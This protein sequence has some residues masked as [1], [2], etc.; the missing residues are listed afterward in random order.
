MDDVQHE[1]QL[2][3]S[4][5]IQYVYVHFMNTSCI[6]SIAA[7][8]M[9]DW[10]LTFSD[11]VRIMWKRPMNGAKVLFILNRYIYVAYYITAIMDN[12]SSHASDKVRM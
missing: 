7:V 3:W 4:R 11:E 2:H 12:F 10:F 9:Y 1:R 5:C 8:T 6:D